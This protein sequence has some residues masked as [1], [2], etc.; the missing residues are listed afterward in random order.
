MLSI[1]IP[2]LNEEKYLPLLLASIKKQVFSDYEIIVSDGKSEDKT[3][4]IALSAGCRVVED[5]GRSPARQRNIGAKVA[6]GDTIMFL[7]AD[8]LLPDYFV[9]AAY[10]E[11]RLKKLSAAGFY[12]KF[13]SPKRIYRIFE[14]VYR[15][16][17]FFGQFFFPA[18]V[19]VGIMASKSAHDKINGFD[20]TIFIGEDYDYIK[21]LAGVGR[22]RMIA[23]TFLYFSVRRLDK[24]GVI[25]VLWKWFIGGIYFIIRGPIRKKIVK[26]EFGK[27]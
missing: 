27:Y 16:I 23:S 5:E 17:S 25:P 14:P 6:K 7:D 26:Y 12:L 2:T 18:S 10:D 21:R 15:T 4:S 20:E 24:E 13:N 3:V 11:F 19:G 22:Y 9:P 1:I 8:T